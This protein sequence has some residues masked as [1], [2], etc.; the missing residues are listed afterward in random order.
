MSNLLK[1]KFL[2]GVMTVAIMFVGAV[3]VATPAAA[4]CSITTT[5]RVGSTGVEVQC[6]QG[7]VGATADG[8][9]GPLTLASVKTFQASHGL[10]ADGI[11]GP[12]SRAVLNGTAS[13]GAG[14]LCPNGN[15]L[16]SNCSL[17]PNAQ[18]GALCPNG[19]TLA[20][21]C[22]TAPGSII[23]GTGTFGSGTT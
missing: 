22:A 18:S 19:N 20:S 3:A 9:F 4:D 23:S 7:K 1:S 16:A 21:N 12:L 14:A 15:T 13:A 5:L 6:L 8:S 17:A 11:V 2:L 10:V